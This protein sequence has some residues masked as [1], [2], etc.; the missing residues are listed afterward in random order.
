MREGHSRRELPADFFSGKKFSTF[1]IIVSY[2]D[3]EI[4]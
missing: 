1:R 3:V 4:I 2:P